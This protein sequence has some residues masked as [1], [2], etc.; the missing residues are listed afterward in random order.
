[1]LT[2]KI[3][4]YLVKKRLHSGLFFKYYAI[5]LLGVKKKRSPRKYPP[6]PLRSP[7]SSSGAP[8]A[9]QDVSKWLL[10]APGAPEVSLSP[11][12]SH[13]YYKAFASRRACKSKGE[14]ILNAT[15]NV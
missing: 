8:P 15:D 12:D 2:E 7:W 10:E 4:F 13:Y 9:P 14:A 5:T 11:V 6:E 3:C 1:M